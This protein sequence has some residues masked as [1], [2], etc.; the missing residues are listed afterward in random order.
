MMYKTVVKRTIDV[1]CA[2][3]G[4]VALSP[5]LLTIALIVKIESNGSV[6]FK[7]K[8]IG[9]GKTQF[10]ILKFRTM[11]I[12]TPRDVPTHLLD[13]PEKHITRV[14][15]VLRRTSLDELP[16]LFNILKGDMSFIGPRPAL[17][18]QHNLIRERDKH[19]ANEILPGLTGWAQ[20]NG[21]DE[22]SIVQKAKH[23]GEYARNISFLT[24]V[25][26]LIKTGRLMILAM[27]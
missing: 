4:L 5:I 13:N 17:W 16:Q 14:G 22:L 18:N 8:R 12:D 19:G 10:E 26:I 24:D 11:K 7:Q 15:K 20:I 2:L 1:I 6:L 3:L 23:D 25:R 9:K 21:R 27:D